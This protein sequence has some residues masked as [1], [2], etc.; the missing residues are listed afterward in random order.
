MKQN[1]QMMHSNQNY[2]VM[3]RLKQST[4]GYTKMIEVDGENFI[5]FKDITQ[6]NVSS[7]MTQGFGFNHVFSQED[8]QDQVF[9]KVYEESIQKVFEGHNVAVLCY[10]QSQAGKSYTIF[11]EHHRMNCRDTQ[12]EQEPG[13]VVRTMQALFKKA[14]EIQEIRQF[15]FSLSMFEIY[16]DQVRDLASMLSQESP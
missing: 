6:K 11:G 3:A 8:S 14:R 13:L 4:K 2:K 7:Q 15:Q 5:Q 16:L 10:G 12:K 1:N 9:D